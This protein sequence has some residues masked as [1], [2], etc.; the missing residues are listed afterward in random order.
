MQKETLKKKSAN[1]ADRKKSL[2][3]KAILMN[4]IILHT[5]KISYQGFSM[6]YYQFV[7]LYKNILH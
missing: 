4:S 7:N 3:K 6:A 2:N 5:L 1:K